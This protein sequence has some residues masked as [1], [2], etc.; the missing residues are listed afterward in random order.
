MCAA[1]SQSQEIRSL[2]GVRACGERFHRFLLS[3][4]A[5]DS[6]GGSTPTDPPA[7][8][9]VSTG[10]LTEGDAAELVRLRQEKED[11][12]GKL[13]DREGRVS[14]LEDENR[15]LK[16]PPTPAAVQKRGFL[17]GLADFFPR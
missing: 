11:L 10:K 5:D 7:A 4:D 16:S 17:D 13:K 9:V 6:S 3:P 12:A 8:G 2:S 1:V 14:Q 15:K